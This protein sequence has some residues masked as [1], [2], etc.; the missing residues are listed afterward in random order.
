[1]QGANTTLA[2]FTTEQICARLSSGSFSTFTNRAAA[3]AAG[4]VV[5]F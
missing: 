5:R 4:A 3:A 1:M 2:L